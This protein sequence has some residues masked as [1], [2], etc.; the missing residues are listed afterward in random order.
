MK[1]QHEY[2]RELQEK[3]ESLFE[4]MKPV[5]IS[6]AFDAPQFAEDWA[7]VAA[8]TVKCRSLEVMALA[9]KIN[10]KG[11]IMRSK[12]TNRPLLAWR[13]YEELKAAA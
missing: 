3:A 6:P 4:S 11:D 9:P 5:Q 7:R 12:K 1:P 10:K 2:E 8:R 13:R